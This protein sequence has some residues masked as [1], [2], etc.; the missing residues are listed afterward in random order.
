MAYTPIFFGASGQGS[1]R[2]LASGFQNASG[3]NIA[4]GT[5][6]AV[7]SDSKLIKLDVSNEDSV[8]ALVGLAQTDIPNG[9][10]GQVLD[11][12]RLEDVAIAIAVG[13]SVYVSKTPGG[14]TSTKPEVGVE[15]FEVN[16]FVIFLGVVVKNE[17]NSTLLDI[18]LLPTVFGRL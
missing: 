18:K 6:L 17:F 5:V 15:G 2:A 4:K 13:D 8:L 1:S 3:E 10:N 7:N 16:D 14:I 11:S 9:A 12:G